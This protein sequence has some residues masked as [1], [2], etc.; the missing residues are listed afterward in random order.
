MEQTPALPRRL[1]EIVEST[2]IELVAESYLLH[3]AP[4]LGALVRASDGTNHVYAVVGLTRTGSIDPGRRPVA[5]GYAEET[6]EDIYRRHPELPQ[7]LRTEFHALV[8]G[9]RENGQIR[10]FLPPRPPRL[11]GFVHECSP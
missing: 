8:V 4:P 11:H 2:T 9:F 3:D 10:R 1:G 6:E 7:L 5:R